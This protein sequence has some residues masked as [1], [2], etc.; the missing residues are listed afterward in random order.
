MEIDARIKEVTAGLC[1]GQTDD[2]RAAAVAEA[3]D[4]LKGSGLLAA[5]VPASLSGAGLSAGGVAEILR[6]LA[7]RDGSLAQI[8]QSHFTF[9]RWLVDPALDSPSAEW[10]GRLVGGTLVAN[11]QA[12]GPEPVVFQGGRLSGVKRWA[13]GSPY[14]DV[15]AVTARRPGEAA[16]SLAAFVPADRAGVEVADDYAAVGQS[17]TGSGTVRLDGVAVAEGEVREFADA[18]ALPAYG[19]TAQLYHAAIDVGLAEQAFY[20]AVEL[21]GTP[22]PDDLTARLAGELSATL[23][24]ATSSLAAA[25]AAVDALW[26]D[27]GAPTAKR[28]AASLAVARAR[29]VAAEAALE[30]TAGAFDLTGTRGTAP[31]A[32]LDR[33]WRDARTHTL[34]G[35]RREKLAQI[36]RAV[37]GGP[38]E[39]QG[40]QF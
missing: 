3:V 32:G 38:V 34:H 16:Q 22:D 5:H 35:R 23:W 21:A 14:A 13:S 39:P 1:P 11:A 10:A 17:F 15:L 18:I 40:P 31:G 37:L 6:G 19:A 4:R 27:W 2:E 30:V 28:V 8:P 25:S 12:E 36:G 29:S 33:A 26:G 9:T 7:R 20:R 24:A